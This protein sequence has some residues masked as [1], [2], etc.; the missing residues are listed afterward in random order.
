M[1]LD[2]TPQKLL[3]ETVM[4]FQWGPTVIVNSTKSNLGGQSRGD[5]GGETSI[6]LL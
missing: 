4:F 1:A 3:T 5:K 2:K 6:K